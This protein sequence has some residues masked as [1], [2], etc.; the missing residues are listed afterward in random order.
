MSRQAALKWEARRIRSYRDFT[1][2][3]P[4]YNKTDDGGST[5]HYEATTCP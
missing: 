1:G 4:R 5:N 3:N 2:R